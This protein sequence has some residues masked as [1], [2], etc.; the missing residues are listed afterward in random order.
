MLYHTVLFTFAE[1]TAQEVIDDTLDRLRAM[2][3]IPAVRAV[4]AGPNLVPAGEDG[5]THGLTLVF[6]STAAMRSEFVDHPLHRA[7]LR[8]QLPL[9]SRYIAMDVESREGAR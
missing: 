8:D 3:A 6:D 2:I 1:D 7:V 5:W 4:A 9:F